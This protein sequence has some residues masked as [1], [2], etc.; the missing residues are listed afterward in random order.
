[1]MDRIS[2]SEVLAKRNVIDPFLN[3]RVTGDE[4]W[5]TF[6]N[7]VRKLSSSKRGEAA[8]TEAKPGLTSRKFLLYIWFD[9]KAIIY[10]E[11]LPYG[12]T[13]NSDICCQELDRLKL[14]ID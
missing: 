13:L 9:W 12:Q 6:D 14:A 8:Q 10:Y 5:V 4:K 2:V 3:W 7:I 11:L 1:M